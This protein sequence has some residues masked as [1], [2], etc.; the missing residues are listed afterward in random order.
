MGMRLLIAFPLPVFPAGIPVWYA[1]RPLDE[2]DTLPR[3]T[4]LWPGQR[5]SSGPET[6]RALVEDPL[7]TMNR[8]KEQNLR[9][10]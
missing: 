9:L 1:R 10:I 8:I 5:H 2:A 4:G 7:T 6:G 3:P